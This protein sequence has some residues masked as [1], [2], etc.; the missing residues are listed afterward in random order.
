MKR[1]TSAIRKCIRRSR[2]TPKEQQI[3]AGITEA[4]QQVNLHKQGK[5]QL[6]SIEQVLNEL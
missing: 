4:V 1:A 6:R 2:L 5:I 3:L